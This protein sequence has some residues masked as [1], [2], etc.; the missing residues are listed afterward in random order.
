MI[1][2]GKPRKIT[3]RS[4]APSRFARPSLAADGKDTG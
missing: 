4:V 1:D 3:R 2:R